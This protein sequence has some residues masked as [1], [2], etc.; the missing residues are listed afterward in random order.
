MSHLGMVR[1]SVSRHCPICRKAAHQQHGLLG[2]PTQLRGLVRDGRMRGVQ[3]GARLDLPPIVVSLFCFHTY[4]T[5]RR[6][7]FELG[8][9]DGVLV[10]PADLTFL[11]TNNRFVEIAYK[12]L[13]QE[14]GI[15]PSSAFTHWDGKIVLPP[16]TGQWDYFIPPACPGLTK[17]G[18]ARINHSIE[19]YIYNILG[20]QVD[21]RLSILGKSSPAVEAQQ[22]FL[23][24]VEEFRPTSAKAY[25][26]ILAISP[27]S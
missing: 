17:S 3:P 2:E 18:Q 11:P 5:V 21:V 26:G 7:L 25:S 24:H 19:V 20:S 14:F 10:L 4:F 22:E 15:P 9:P 16:N 6:V 23:Q 13:C 8:G 1:S 12:R 27:G